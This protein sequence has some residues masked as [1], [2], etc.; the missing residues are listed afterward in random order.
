MQANQMSDRAYYVTRLSENIGRTPVEGYLVCSGVPVART[1]WQEYLGR[2]VDPKDEGML[3]T[4]VR[5]YRSEKEVF[6]PA[7]IASFEGKTVTDS[8]PSEWVTAQ[9][10]SEYHRG[11]AQNVRRGEGDLKDCL[12][13]DLIIKDPTLINKIENGLREVSCGYYCRYVP[14]GTSGD[15]FAQESIRG[16]HVAVVPQGRAGERIA[17]RDSAPDK[18]INERKERKIKMAKM[19]KRFFQALGFK[20]WAQDAAPEEV[21]EGFE[22]LQ[23]PEAKEVD[24]SPEPEA[25]PAPESGGINHKI[26]EKLD[27]VLAVLEKLVEVKAAPAAE[28]PKPAP[29]PKEPEE[30]LDALADS[31]GKEQQSQP[32]EENQMGQ[33]HEKEALQGAGQAPFLDADAFPEPEVLSG[34]ELPKNPIPGADHKMVR[35]MITAMKP[36]IAKIPNRKDRQAAVDSMKQTLDSFRAPVSQSNG[37]YAQF[38]KLQRAE[39]AVAKEREK[40]AAEAGPEFGDNLQKNYFRKHVTKVV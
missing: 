20:T 22:A 3:D 34:K 2:E 4:K 19:N 28:A 33:D 17:I 35:D 23:K 29:E 32:E 21:A 38:L 39:D 8:H 12:L 37:S 14:I 11:H 6:D 7:T 36:I 13:A 30:E 24:A 9:T 18:F 31:F 10:E 25:A 1:G 5:V 16:N 27:S 40:K 26:L 15:M